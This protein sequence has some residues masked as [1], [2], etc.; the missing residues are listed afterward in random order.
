VSGVITRWSPGSAPLQDAMRV[1][2]A[3]TDLGVTPSGRVVVGTDHGQVIVLDTSGAVLTELDGHRARI[4]RVSVS[5]DG[6]Q[7]ASADTDGVVLVHTL[8]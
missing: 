3:V 5:P 8:P 4:T 6:H 7:V 1:D 2:G